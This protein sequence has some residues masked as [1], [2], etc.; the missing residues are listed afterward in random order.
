MKQGNINRAYPS[1]LKLRDF[2][3]P[4][5]KAYAIY[6]LS[7]CV[8]N[9]HEF[10]AEEERKYLADYNGSISDDGNTISFE[11]PTDCAAFR[12][13]VEELCNVDVDIEIEP[14]LLTEDDLGEQRLTPADI[15]NLEGFV[16]FA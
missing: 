16:T 4:V 2:N 9:A 6:K 3:L 5:K 14:V 1:L 11:T 7:V 13:K 10:A 8:E 12:D 15:F